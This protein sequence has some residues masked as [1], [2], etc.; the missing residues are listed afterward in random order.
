MEL[1]GIYVFYGIIAIVFFFLQRTFFNRAGHMI[2]KTLPISM[3]LL[4]FCVCLS[5]SLIRIYMIKSKDYYIQMSVDEVEVMAGFYLKTILSAIIGC[6]L[7]IVSAKLF[8]N[9]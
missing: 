5:I 4:S 1:F 9:K 7:G 2:I 6:S 8:R 3:S